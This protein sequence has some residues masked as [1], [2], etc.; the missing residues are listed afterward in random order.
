[1]RRMKH[2]LCNIGGTNIATAS[3]DGTNIGHTLTFKT[4]TFSSA[5]DVI[6]KLQTRIDFDSAAIAIAGPTD[7]VR[8]RLTNGELFF[9]ARELKTEF[10]LEHI[11]LVNDL[12]A[13]AW[14]LSC[15]ATRGVSTI[16]A[17]ESTRASVKSVVGVGT[18]FGLSFIA[19]TRD[20]GFSVI[21]SEGGHSTACATDDFEAQVI[22]SLRK[23]GHVSIEDILSGS[24][25]LRLS[26]SISN[27]LGV[28]SKATSPEE[29]CKFAINKTCKVCEVSFDTFWSF[30]GSHCGNIALTMKSLGGVYI[31]GGIVPSY[32]KELKNSRFLE[33]FL[34]KGKFET[35][36]HDIPI[37]V[38][39][40][41]HVE[42]EGLA[43]LLGSKAL[44]R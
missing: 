44:T 31:C 8:G 24:G 25:L 1:M 22:A 19:E 6:Q 12:E 26:S 9:D 16:W 14:R 43:N 13:V 20:G 2:V 27:L 35:F 39:V 41:K 36:L 18:G 29:V 23:F 42:I 30:L 40:Q 7:G 21:P 15:E 10:K 11:C 32:V 17:G 28:Q 38:I 4:S 33:K 3:F 37:K 34:S 5:A